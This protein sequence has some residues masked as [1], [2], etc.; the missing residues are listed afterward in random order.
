MNA[1]CGLLLTRT[2][3]IPSVLYEHQ[4]HS[5]I[6]SAMSVNKTNG[7]IQRPK[8]TKLVCLTDF[9]VCFIKKLT[10]ECG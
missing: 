7:F 1:A 3:Y 5:L 2:R 9:Y 6:R 4:R 8:L 10:R